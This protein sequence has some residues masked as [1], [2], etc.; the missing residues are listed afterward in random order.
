M[1]RFSTAPT[2]QFS[3]I[4]SICSSR[5]PFSSSPSSA[6][7]S[8]NSSCCCCYFRITSLLRPTF[9]YC[10]IA[11]GERNE[12]PPRSTPRI[13]PE[14]SSAWLSSFSP[15]PYVPPPCW[16]EVCVFSSSLVGEASTLSR[17]RG[18]GP[19][20]LLRFLFR[21]SYSRSALYSLRI[22]SSTSGYS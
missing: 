12:I 10:N 9:V 21:L 16:P 7:P 11:F 20:S 15:P 22:W 1:S 6:T 3:F 8:F 5:L 13:A 2:T 4:I 19:A 17:E 14:R 18:K